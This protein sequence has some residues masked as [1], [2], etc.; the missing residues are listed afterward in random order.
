MS[1]PLNQHPRGTERWLVYRKGNGNNVTTSD[2]YFVYA[3]SI[4]TLLDSMS[5]V[6]IRE[7]KS[8][9][10]WQLPQRDVNSNT[11]AE[12]NPEQI[13]VPAL[14]FQL[15]DEQGEILMLIGFSIYDLRLIVYDPAQ[16]YG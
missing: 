4:C 2:E 10:N 16:S 3:G 1:L 11:R 5:I 9:E 12:R 7:W 8:I 13:I 6:G 14:I 15:T